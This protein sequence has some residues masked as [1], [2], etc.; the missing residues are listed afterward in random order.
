MTI[1]LMIIIIII[2]EL[3]PI[4]NTLFIKRQKIINNHQIYQQMNK[5]KLKALHIDTKIHTAHQQSY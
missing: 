2:F 4:C 5:I 3:H 1:I